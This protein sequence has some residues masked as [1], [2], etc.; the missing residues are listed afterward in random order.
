MRLASAH[1]EPV[2]GS[3]PVPHFK[4]EAALLAAGCSLVGRA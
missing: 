2:E 3:G 4:E 1:P